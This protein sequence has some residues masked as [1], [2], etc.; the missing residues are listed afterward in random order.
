MLDLVLSDVGNDGFGLDWVEASPFGWTCD[1]VSVSGR[2]RKP[3]HQSR[4]VTQKI[5]SGR[6]N[7]ADRIWTSVGRLP[8]WSKRLRFVTTIVAEWLYFLGPKQDEF[9]ARSGWSLEDGI[10]FEIRWGESG[11]DAVR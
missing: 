4:S 6:R 10:V 9:G 2:K 8:W 3:M 5:A 7:P 1:L 11:S